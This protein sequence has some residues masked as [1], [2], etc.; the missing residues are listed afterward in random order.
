MSL[1]GRSFH[2]SLSDGIPVYSQYANLIWCHLKSLFDVSKSP[3][4]WSTPAS[5]TR[6]FFLHHISSQAAVSFD[7]AIIVF[8]TKLLFTSQLSFIFRNLRMAMFFIPAVH[9]VKFYNIFFYS[10]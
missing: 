4:F 2:N 1:A 10:T 5:Y 3:F 7:V 8:L 6:H 9:A